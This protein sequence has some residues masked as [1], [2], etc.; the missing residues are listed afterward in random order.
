MKR[1]FWVIPGLFVASVVIGFC[2][3]DTS[4]VNDIMKKA[5]SNKKGLRDQIATELKKTTPDWAD[6]QKKSK[7]FAKLASMLTKFKPGDE[8]VKGYP[9][10]WKKLSEAYAAEVKS[11][12]DAVG[13]KDKPAAEKINDKL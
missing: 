5:H 7:E 6:L 3:D 4:T 2:G 12:D 8:G 1:A 13:K 11:L 10:G 9:K